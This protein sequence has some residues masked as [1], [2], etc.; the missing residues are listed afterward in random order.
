MPIYSTTKDGSRIFC[1]EVDSI[2]DTLDVLTD[3]SNTDSVLIEFSYSLD[4]ITYSDYVIDQQVF[5]DSIISAQVDSLIYFKIK[6]TVQMLSS[7]TV[8]SFFELSEVKINDVSVSVSHIEMSPDSGILT[9]TK[10]SALLNPY[11]KSAQQDV[12]VKKISKSISDV[13]G[14]DTTYFRTEPQKTNYT[15]QTYTLLNVAEQKELRVVIK[16]NYIPDNKTRFAEFDIDFQDEL[17][18]HIVKEVFNEVFPDKKPNANDFLFLPLTGQMYQVSAPYDIKEFMNESTYYK[19]MLVK[20]ENRADVKQSDEIANSVESL[21]DFDVDFHEDDIANEK[22]NAVKEFN[23]VKFNE[24]EENVSEEKLVA[25][26][27]T[28]IFRWSYNFEDRQNTEISLSYPIDSLEN[29]YSVITWIKLSENTQLGQVFTIYDEANQQVLTLSYVKSSNEFLAY[30]VS[31][32]QV[33]TLST[34][35]NGNESFVNKWIGVALNYAYTDSKRLLSISVF[36][37]ELNLLQEVADTAVAEC[38]ILKQVDFYGGQHYANIRIAKTAIT[39]PVMK[40]ILQDMLPEVN[41]FYVVDNAVPHIK[42]I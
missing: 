16:D 13:F 39:K 23:D 34:D 42:N 10:T 15:F 38:T 21:I 20:Y 32:S 41:S 30:Y 11:R 28:E 33:F 17:E 7:S 22:A 40:Q 25:S 18:I 26:N 5:I 35:N 6:I 24:A 19:L 3:S 4:N 37:T 36:D 8:L 1:F 14:F 29:Q 2:V 12:L 9:T 31:G 27:G